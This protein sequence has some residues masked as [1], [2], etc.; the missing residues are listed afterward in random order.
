MLQ[1]IRA[2][3]REYIQLPRPVWALAGARFVNAI[4]AYVYPFLTLLLTDRIGFNKEEAG[5]ILMIAM[6]MVVPGSLLG[7]VLADRLGRKRL[8]VIAQILAA[9]CIGI[10][11]F[12]P[13]DRNIVWFILAEH[14]FSGLM[15]PASS[16]ATYD[17]TTVKN[18]K[19]AFSL[20][21]LA[22][23]LGFAVGLLLG[24]L[25]YESNVRWLF[26]GDAGTTFLSLIFI[27]LLLPETLPSVR[28]KMAAEENASVSEPA[29]ILAPGEK[30]AE[31]SALSL[32]FRHP[33][34]LGFVVLMIVPWFIYSQQ[35][36]TMPMFT[37]ELYPENGALLY[38][39][40]MSFNALLVVFLT[41]P[42]IRITRKLK[43][44]TNVALHALLYGLGF[45]ML[46]LF[47]SPAAFYL[48]VF[49]WTCGEVIGTTN[50]QVFTANH[51]PSSHRG[52]F[53]SILPLISGTGRAV[54]PWI[55]G[56]FLL[57]RPT[58]DV[59]VLCFFLGIAAAVSFLFLGLSDRGTPVVPES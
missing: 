42:L 8:I 14:F 51:T 5:R 1:H 41:I 9:L 30:A 25:L 3:Y 26:L 54:S 7:G 31:G 44:I 22:F 27:I 6:V 4:G 11:G 12:I 36:F 56:I 37:K 10:I 18:R 58:G 28:K 13:L 49:V 34:L 57:T 38:G 52:R 20:L 35:S 46:A 50:I 33:L 48:S 40:V 45:G 23:N 21:Y 16:A 47:H 29:P 17:L 55:T 53:S 59:W 2:T 15:M 43:P 24:G 32:L 19:A 39:K